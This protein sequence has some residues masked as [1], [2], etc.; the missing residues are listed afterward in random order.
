MHYNNY[1][2]RIFLLT[3]FIF[4][5]ISSC[6]R[7]PEPPAE[8]AGQSIIPVFEVFGYARCQNCPIV[9]HAVDSLKKLY[10]DSIAV[11]EYHLRWDGGDTISPEDI[12]LKTILYAISNAAPVTII[13][14]VH[15]VDGAES[16]ESAQIE[17][18]DTYYKSLRLLNDS[19]NLIISFDTTGDSLLITFNC[20]SLQSIDTTTSVLFVAITED[21]VFFALSGAEDSVY[22][23]VVR[24]LLLL[25]SNLPQ[26]VS[27]KKDYLSG[28]T[29][30]AMIQDTVNKNILSVTQRRF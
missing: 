1:R 28:K 26:S 11:L 7:V 29:V 22:N 13:Q 15:R 19:I 9:E 21:S 30:V 25:P 24:K 16:D 18:F 6:S 23:N 8:E 17:K 20:D 5:A 2:M 10:G 3:F 4:I 14:G 27:F 12:D